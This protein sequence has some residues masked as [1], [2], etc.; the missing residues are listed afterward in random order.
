MKNYVGV[1]IRKTSHSMIKISVLI[2]KTAREILYTKIFTNKLHNVLNKNKQK[3]E[4]K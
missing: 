1:T 2:T 3:A 4:R